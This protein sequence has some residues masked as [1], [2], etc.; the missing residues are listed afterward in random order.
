MSVYTFSSKIIMVIRNHYRL[1][2]CTVCS[3]L[4]SGLDLPIPR[5]RL[6]DMLQPSTTGCPWCLGRWLAASASPEPLPLHLLVEQ[7]LSSLG[8]GGILDHPNPSIQLLAVGS[9]P[10]HLLWKRLFRQ[11]HA[12]GALP[13]LWDAPAVPLPISTSS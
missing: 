2:G 5:S 1:L 9:V 8:C 10:C 7:G 13:W 6:E 11:V 3:K 12:L 4:S